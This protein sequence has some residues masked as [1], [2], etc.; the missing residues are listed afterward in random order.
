MPVLYGWRR[1]MIDLTWDE[2]EQR[3]VA[4]G[5]SQKEAHEMRLAQEFGEEGDCDGDLE[6]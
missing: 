5:Y 1:V 6:Y 4:A 2:F 3:L